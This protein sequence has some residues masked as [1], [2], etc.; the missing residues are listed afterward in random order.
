MTSNS[1]TR[2]GKKDKE[3]R[4]RDE[5]VKT[6]K[7]E[8]KE[9]PATIKFVNFLENSSKLCL[10]VTA[11]GIG[12]IGIVVAYAFLF[13]NVNNTD[14]RMVSEYA[15]VAKTLE[16]VGLLEKPDNWLRQTV[17]SV[18]EMIPY[19]LPS[20]ILT[21]LMNSVLGYPPNEVDVSKIDREAAKRLPTEDVPSEK[22]YYY[23]RMK[24]LE[25]GSI[26]PTR[27]RMMLEGKGKQQKGLFSRGYS[28]QDLG[29][30]LN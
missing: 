27:V 3:S 25:Q 20:T 11:F 5:K 18:A 1:K 22:D 26:N 19:A 12:V 2:I 14:I 23:N 10:K 9:K 15:N 16:D 21:N 24:Q 17:I 6:S 13:G 29:W 8:K 7:N 4:E 28:N 30:V